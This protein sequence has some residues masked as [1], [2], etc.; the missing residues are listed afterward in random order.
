MPLQPDPLAGGALKQL[1]LSQ[2]P[3]HAGAL[4]IDY[5]FR[6]WSLSTLDLHIDATSSG[7]YH[8]VAFGNQ[9]QDSYTLVNAKVSLANITFSRSEGELTVSAWGKNLGDKEYV[10]FAFPVGDPAVAVVQTFGD[11]RTYGLDISY[12]F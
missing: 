8:Y 10:V 9:R 4:S 11:P 7:R 3:Q 6:P 2:T 1:Y 12:Q 5:S